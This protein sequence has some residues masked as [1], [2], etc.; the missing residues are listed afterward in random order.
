MSLVLF[1]TLWE[2]GA[3][4]WVSSKHPLSLFISLSLSLSLSISISLL[5]SSFASFVSP[6]LSPT[7]PPLQA[8]LELIALPA[9][10]SGPFLILVTL[11]AHCAVSSELCQ[12]QSCTDISQKLPTQQLHNPSCPHALTL[13]QAPLLPAHF[14]PC[15]QHT[16]IRPCRSLI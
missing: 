6:S 9:S 3:E 16:Q 10:A 7:P 13:S 11:L 1:C 14:V 5:P 12:A 2:I 15:T 4:K 8:G